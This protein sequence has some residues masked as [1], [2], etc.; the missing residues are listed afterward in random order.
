MQVRPFTVHVHLGHAG[1]I[2]GKVKARLSCLY[3]WSV[4]SCIWAIDMAC[5]FII[6]KERSVTVGHY[7]KMN[8]FCMLKHKNMYKRI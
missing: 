5:N 3:N 4:I 2:L 8:S 7:S 6:I 1:K